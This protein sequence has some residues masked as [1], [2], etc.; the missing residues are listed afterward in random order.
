MV[1][2]NQVR[3]L[4]FETMTVGV[5]TRGVTYTVPSGA[6]VIAPCNPPLVVASRTVAPCLKCR[7]SIEA[8]EAEYPCKFV[9]TVVDGLVVECLGKLASDPYPLLVHGPERVLCGLEGV[10]PESWGLPIQVSPSS[11]LQQIHEVGALHLDIENSI[12]H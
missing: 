3:P 5:S 12:R 4:S 2:S 1:L 7:S 10:V 8:G 11:S 9:V 6:E